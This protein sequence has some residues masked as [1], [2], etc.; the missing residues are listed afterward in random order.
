MP[1]M[2]KVMKNQDKRSVLFGYTGSAKGTVMSLT[3]ARS[4]FGFN[5]QLKNELHLI[6]FPFTR[7]GFPM[8]THFHDSQVSCDK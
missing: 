8:Y 2:V 6:S 4:E 5:L 1:E 3:H 7:M